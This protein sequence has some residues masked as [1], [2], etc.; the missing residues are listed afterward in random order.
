M[1]KTSIII[2][3]AGKGTRM[4]NPLPKV[5]VNFKG[6]PMIKHVLEN[7]ENIGH[8]TIVVVGY[9]KNLV[10]EELKDFNVKFIHQDKQLGTGHAVLVTENEFTD[11]KG[12]ILILF[13][14]APLISKSVIQEFI[15]FHQKQKYIASILTK[16]SL[17]PRGCARIVRDENG[18]FLKSIENKDLTHEFKHIKEINVGV[19]LINS[20]ILFKTLKNVTNN[21]SQNE[22]YLPDVINILSS[23]HK[24]GVYKSNDIPELFSFNTIED[25]KNAEKIKFYNCL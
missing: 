6:K 10:K 3:G 16:D 9:K 1:V 11:F 8:T 13:G 17:D 22:Y 21:N 5:L 4:K 12:D 24:I 7:C 25:L 18:N 19:M 2:L 14:D 23:S 15:N 20:E